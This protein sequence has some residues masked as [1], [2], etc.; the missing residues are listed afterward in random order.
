MLVLFTVYLILYPFEAIVPKKVKNSCD[1]E[2]PGI[3]TGPGGGGRSGAAGVGASSASFSRPSKRLVVL[4]DVLVLAARRSIFLFLFFTWFPRDWNEFQLSVRLTG[5][6]VHR[7]RTCVHFA[8]SRTYCFCTHST[9][10]SINGN[11]HL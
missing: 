5:L 10:A 9:I 11:L 3:I 1:L 2:R 7:C 6:Y 8:H 4:T